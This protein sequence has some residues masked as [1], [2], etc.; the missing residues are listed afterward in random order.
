VTE[1]NIVRERRRKWLAQHDVN[2]MCKKYSLESTYK[3]RRQ[4]TQDEIDKYIKSPNK[5]EYLKSIGK[6]EME[7]C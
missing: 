5:D 3:G 6:F 1:I 4:L 2:E 7:V